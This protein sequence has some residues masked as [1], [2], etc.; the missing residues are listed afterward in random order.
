MTKNDNNDKTDKMTKI[1][2]I[3]FKKKNCPKKIFT[4]KSIKNYQKLN[5]EQNDDGPTDRPTDR[6]TK[7]LIESCSTRLKR[8]WR[9]KEGKRKIPQISIII[10]SVMIL[11]QRH[12]FLAI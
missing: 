12:H 8:R 7:R 1:A 9:K 3:F 2:K 10:S 4:K 5:K 11:C 6:L